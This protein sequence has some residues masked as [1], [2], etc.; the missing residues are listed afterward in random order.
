MFK[1]MLE[2][3]IIRGEDSTGVLINDRKGPTVYKEVDVPWLGLYTDPEFCTAMGSHTK[4]VLIGHNRAATRG[5]ITKENAHPFQCGH[6]IGAHNG[7]LYN[8]TALEDH[9]EFEVDSENLYHHMSIH[10][11]SDTIRK[12]NGAFALVWYNTEEG[13][14]NFIRNSQRTLFFAYAKDNTTMYWA[15]E[16]WMLDRA[17][18]KARIKLGEIHAF[19]QM[20]HYKLEVPTGGTWMQRKFKKMRVKKLDPWKYQ[21]PARPANWGTKDSGLPYGRNLPIVVGDGTTKNIHPINY[22]PNRNKA[23]LKNYFRGQLVDFITD[24]PIQKGKSNEAS[25]IVGHVIGTEIEVRLNPKFDTTNWHKYA[26]ATIR[27]SGRVKK[28][29]AGYLLITLGSIKPFKL[30]DIISRE[31]VQVDPFEDLLTDDRTYAI[32]DKN[33]V[34]FNHYARL[35]DKGCCVCGSPV[36][37]EDELKL[38]WWDES[39]VCPGC[40]ISEV[41]TK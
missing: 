12:L 40:D 24:F 16:L 31:K 18:Q 21:A 30:K 34:T 2:L 5:K 26:I 29:K 39:P 38:D 35:L 19:R 15:S 8:R 27:Y 37:I 25:H 6:I 4:N 9:K 17:A 3:D 22:K 28:V 33:F 7:T 23:D 20:C 36:F 32:G 1:T 11:V 13:T 14:I 10:G 41:V